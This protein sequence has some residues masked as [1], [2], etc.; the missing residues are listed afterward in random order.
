MAVVAL[1]AVSAQASA[2]SV[3]VNLSS[4][5][6]NLV[7]HDSKQ[8]VHKHHVKQQRCHSDKHKH[9]V[10]KKMR[11]KRRHDVRINKKNQCK[12]CR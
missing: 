3:S 8:S 9:V 1:G 6:V 5:G 10:A 2:A 7:V 4:A 11:D 12:R